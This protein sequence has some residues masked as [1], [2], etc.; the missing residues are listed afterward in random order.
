M[1]TNSINLF[2][3]INNVTM[4]ILTTEVKEVVAT[5]IIPVNRRNFSAADLWSIQKRRRSASNR[6]AF[7]LS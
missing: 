1:R 5:E 2:A 7:S 4:Q 3:A 6:R